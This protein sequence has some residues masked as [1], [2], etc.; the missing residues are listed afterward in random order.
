MLEITPGNTFV[1]NTCPSFARFLGTNGIY[2]DVTRRQFG[3]VPGL[4]PVSAYPASQNPFSFSIVGQ[5]YY[6]NL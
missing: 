3:E 2:A 5:E 6:K 1:P 4:V